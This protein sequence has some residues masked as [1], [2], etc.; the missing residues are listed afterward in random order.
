LDALRTWLAQEGYPGT[1]ELQPMNRGLGSTELWSFRPDPGE[2]KLVVRIFPH[3][4]F[5]GA[6]REALAM[7]AAAGHA[8]PVPD[9][10]ARGAIDNRPLL[11][12]SFVQGV[13]GAHAL[14][15]NPDQAYA[16]GRAMGE[17]LGHLHDVVAPEG[18]SATGA[19][20]ERGGPSLAPLRDAF[21]ALPDQDRLLHLDYHPL[22]VLMLDGR[23]T[24]VI[25]WENTLAGPPHMDLARSQAILR[26][27]AIGHVE[28]PVPLDAIAVFERG[29]VE[30]HAATY[31]PDPHPALSSAWGLAMTVDDLE[32][33]AHKP[34][35]P[36]SP[37]AVARLT[38]ER[39]AAI[40]AA[41][42]GG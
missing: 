7:D 36:V 11:V 19:W 32:R 29:L 28:S 2:S 16:I 5:R 37:D 26:A 23:V 6:E 41:R 4:A 25:D 1:L 30:G 20:I 42:A 22:N 34:G 33:Q 31:G 35:S 8:L 21:T 38:A 39:D 40:E 9:V 27:I 15:A 13:P 18:L 14:I 24:G 12:T 10:V 17:T 3:G